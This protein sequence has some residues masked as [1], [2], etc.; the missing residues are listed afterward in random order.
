M[1]IKNKFV[2][3][4]LCAVTS[5]ISIAA[6]NTA[7][8]GAVK[9]CNISKIKSLVK[10]GAELNALN[11]SGK[12]VL[13]IA[14]EKRSKKIARYLLRQGAKVTTKENAQSLR[15]FLKGR[16][17]GFFIG[18]WFIPFMWIG[19]YFAISDMVYVETL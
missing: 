9:R 7:L 3:L 1:Y 14:V 19:S 17:I 12:T 10:N 4:M 6:E 15:E 8:F 5:F 18:G 16:A 11:E 2:V 13:D